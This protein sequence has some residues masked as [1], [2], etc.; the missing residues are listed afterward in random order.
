MPLQKWLFPYYALTIPVKKWL[1]W[2]PT[3]LT[4]KRPKKTQTFPRGTHDWLCLSCEA[5]GGSWH[6]PIA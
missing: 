3:E 1:L 2:I 5:S 6:L 4:D